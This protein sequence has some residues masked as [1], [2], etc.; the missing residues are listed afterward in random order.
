MPTEVAGSSYDLVCVPAGCVCDAVGVAP[1]PVGIFRLTASFL[2][3][4]FASTANVAF[5][6]ANIEN[7]TERSH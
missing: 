3:R 6:N 1:A 4:P 5:P 7:I 2:K